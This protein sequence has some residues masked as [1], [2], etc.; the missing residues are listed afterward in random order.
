MRAGGRGDLR[1]LAAV[2]SGRRSHAANAYCRVPIKALVARYV[3]AM[4]H[5]RLR[6]SGR[7]ALLH[8]QRFARRGTPGNAYPV[9]PVSRGE[10]EPHV[11]EWPRRRSR[12]RLTRSSGATDAAQDGPSVASRA[13]CN[14]DKSASRVP[15]MPIKPSCEPGDY[16]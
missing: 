5:V 15:G 10:P 13:D 14:P 8:A 3:L 2:C 1:A 12:R 6:E 4:T 9:V 7:R 11:D 16:P